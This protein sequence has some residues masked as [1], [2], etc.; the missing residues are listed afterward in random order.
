MQSLASLELGASPPEGVNGIGG[1]TQLSSQLAEL[2]QHR[3]VGDL[4]PLGFINDDTS[5]QKC[6][7]Q[8]VSSVGGTTPLVLPD[9]EREQSAD[10]A[11]ADS[12]TSM[13]CVVPC[14]PRA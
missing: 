7:L 6:S 9:E 1:L 5:S 8:P 4:P 10:E 12:K 14:G 11:T 2:L 13:V 3:L